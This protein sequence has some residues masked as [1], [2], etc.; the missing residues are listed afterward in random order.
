MQV[1]LVVLIIIFTSTVSSAQVVINEFLANNDTTAAD[2]NGEFDDWVELFNNGDE[3][4]SLN[5]YFLSDNGTNLSKWT[6]PDTSIGAGGYLIIWTDSDELQSGL[7]TNFKLS[8]GG[9]VIYLTSPDTTVVDLITFYIQSS[10]ISTGRFPNGTGDFKNMTPSFSAPN[11]GDDPDDPSGSIFANNVVNSYDLHFYYDNWE[12]S[13]QYYY[14]VL[15]QEYIPAQLTYNGNVVFDSIGV[16]YKGNSS[17]MMSRHTPKKPFKFKFD[18][19]K[20]QKLFGVERLNFG[21]FVKD[22]SFMREK[23]G[24]DIAR[25]YVPC[26]RT[27][28]ARIL[29]DGELIGLYMAVEQVDELFLSRHFNDNRGNLYKSSDEGTDMGFRGNVQSDYETEYDLQTNS[30]ENDWSRLITMLD[31]LNNTPD[32]L[33][34]DTVSTY[35]DLDNCVRHIAFNMVMSHFDSYTGSGRNFYLY[36]D[37]ISGQFKMIHWDMNETFGAYGNNWNVITQDVVEISNINQ[38]PLIRRIM[39]NAI[40]KQLYLGY[41]TD[42]VNGAASYESVVVMADRI[43][44]LIEEHVLADNNKLYSSQ[45]FND[46]I[47][48]DVQI[49]IGQLLPGIKTFSQ[50]RNQNILMQL[51]ATTVY[52]GDADN[53]GVVNALDILPIGIYF[54]D[55]GAARTSLSYAWEAK[56][57][58]AWAEPAATYADANGDGTVDERDVI[59]IGI[60]W[61]NS[62]NNAANSYEI[63][64]SNDA[65]LNQYRNSFQT[66]YTSLSGDGEAISSIKLLLGSILDIETEIPTFYSLGQNYPNPFNPSTYI[67]FTLPESQTVT[68]AIYD[69]LGKRL[70]TPIDSE[71]YSA[72]QH[73]FILD[74]TELSNGTYFYR[75]DAGN[76]S[77]THKMTVIK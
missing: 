4:V 62:H 5:G 54:L 68:I 51:Y 29:V 40:L 33:F 56:E 23:I 50:A 15:D 41:I 45:Q 18:E 6:F 71:L 47:E 75:I 11:N 38:R 36:D 24:Y 26:P 49:G 59:G 28:Y 16:R 22:P 19:Y 55:E 53:N 10:D 61:G 48:G 72:G 2:Q 63:D 12:D 1:L 20:N 27:A 39:N 70:F 42:M 46:N 14:E 30:N 77:Q 58:I 57:A 67:G 21:N 17:Y 69:L 73:K 65:L 60:N 74:A 44:P 66:L 8:A 34:I 13:L 64:S 76:W 43:K 32:S 3:T 52:P 7:H 37:P 9:E 31:K 35:L 25:Q